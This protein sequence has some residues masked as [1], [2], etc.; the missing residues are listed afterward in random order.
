MN[1]SRLMDLVCGRPVPEEER[2]PMKA[3]AT[4]MNAALISTGVSLVWGI[5]ASVRAP[6]LMLQNVWKV[7]AIMLLGAAFS[8]PVSALMWKLSDTPG[9][10]IDLL[11]SFFVGLL[12]GG[13]VLAAVSPLIGLTYGSSRFMGPTFAQ[14]S[15]LLAL[16]TGIGIFIRAVWVS[17]PEG[18]SRR[19]FLAP[20]VTLAAAFSL[21][22]VQLVAMFSPILP[23][24]TVWDRG[25]D[26]AVHA[27]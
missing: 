4:A 2:G 18:A 14:G 9:R 19:R 13:L 5:G 20:V 25:I 27:E 6:H 1:L 17:R 24:R 16:A 3:L 21:C 7:P 10:A 23:E 26:R 15:V 12:G 11:R 8:L 22:V